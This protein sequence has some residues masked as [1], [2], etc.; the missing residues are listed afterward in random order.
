MTARSPACAASPG[1]AYAVPNYIAH[2][3]GAWYPERPRAD[4]PA[5]GWETEQWNL[6]PGNGINAPEAWANLLADHRGGGKGVTVAVLDTGVAYRDWGAVRQSPDFA[7]HRKFVLPAVRLRSPQPLPAGPQRPRDI[8]R[9]GA[10]PRPP[11][12]ASG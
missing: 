10:S 2:A 5:P 12:T 8:R 4:Q 6:L 3:A 1:V 7:P 9:R 11:T